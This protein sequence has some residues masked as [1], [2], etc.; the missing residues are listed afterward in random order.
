VRR[1][2]RK[3]NQRAKSTQANPNKTK[4]KSLDLLGFPWIYSSE[5]GLFKGLSA[6]K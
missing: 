3:F 2:T 5:S 4:Q 1:F 6:K